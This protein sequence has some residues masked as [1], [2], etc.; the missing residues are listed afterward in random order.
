MGHLTTANL[1]AYIRAQVVYGERL[2]AAHTPDRSGCC[3][4][5]G[6]VAPCDGAVRGQLLVDHFGTR[7]S[8]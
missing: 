8:P 2:L 5:C 1:A 4:R 6:R 7:R 3:R